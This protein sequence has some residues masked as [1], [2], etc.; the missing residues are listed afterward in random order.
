TQ[1]FTTD[2]IILVAAEAIDHA[3]TVAMPAGAVSRDKPELCGEIKIQI[4]RQT[5]V[6]RLEYHHS[7]I[8]RAD[9]AHLVA[10]LGGLD[11]VAAKQNA[12]DDKSDDDKHNS[13]LN[14]CK[15]LSAAVFEAT[16]VNKVWRL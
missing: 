11:H 8:V 2:G 3:V 4:A 1:G 5:A 7:R 14:K 16:H 9:S 6:L 10:H 15:P 13:Q 12:A